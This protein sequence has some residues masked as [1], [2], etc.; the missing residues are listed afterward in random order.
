MCTIY[1]KEISVNG[2]SLK[3]LKSGLQKYIRR[4]NVEKSLYCAG[5]LYSFKSMDGGGR[6]YT[7]F[8]N[9]LLVIC[10]ED[11]CNIEIILKEIPIFLCIYKKENLDEKKIIC[12]FIT[13]LCNSVKGRIC[14]HFKSVF[15]TE[16][17]CDNLENA[18]ENF[19]KNVD[20]KK[21]KSIS[22][23][24]SI[25]CSNK[26]LKS[27]YNKRKKAV[28][29]LFKILEKKWKEV[30]IFYE[31]YKLIGHLKE[32]FLCW[33]VP[34]L[35]I[36][37][38]VPLGIN[39][40]VKLL[41]YSFKNDSIINL[42]DFVYDM[43][44]GI[45][46]KDN[47]ERF[48]LEGAIVYPEA[49]WVNKEYKLNYYKNKKVPLESDIF[50][51]IIRTQLVTSNYKQDTYLASLKDNTKV[52]VKGPFENCTDFFNIQKMK[53][54]MGLNIL[55]YKYI[56]CLPDKWLNGTPLGFRNKCDRFK[57]YTF[58]YSPC[59]I[60]T[61]N[62]HISERE[63]KLWPVTKVVDWSYYS[64]HIIPEKLSCFQMKEYIECILFRYTLGIPD[65]ASRNF[66]N[67]K[68]KIYS[69][70]E[71]VYKKDLKLRKELGKNKCE[72]IITWIIKNYSLFTLEWITRIS[73]EELLDIFSENN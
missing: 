1:R 41:N 31:L 26:K 61:E 63:S 64:F 42:D 52:F 12:S 58:L 8:L 28:Y 2:F 20:N 46:D 40:D 7:N 45:K 59:L 19:E 14:S 32:G 55:N 21:L 44:T 50:K 60:D 36:I 57:L 5:E 72:L 25:D 67:I 17:E 62:L 22:I 33:C 68:G 70:D 4:G 30:F 34:L 66:L 27:P 53:T 47:L 13:K 35:F 15:Y 39:K 18:L 10:M 16:K 9:R 71:D 56:K 3:V 54:K 6:I 38:K 48:A 65:L 29:G 69:I 43:H 73:K 24:F 23:A 37:E 11:V 51:F 49:K